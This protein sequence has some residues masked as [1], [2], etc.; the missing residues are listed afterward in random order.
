MPSGTD[1]HKSTNDNK[2]PKKPSIPAGAKDPTKSQHGLGQGMGAERGIIGTRGGVLGGIGMVV[3]AL[4]GGQK[5]IDLTNHRKPK[6]PDWKH[7]T[8]KSYKDLT[9]DA[10]AHYG[11]ILRNKDYGKGSGYSRQS[12]IERN[13]QYMIQDYNKLN[14][15][16]PNDMAN[17][18]ANYNNLLYD[19]LHQKEKLRVAS[20]YY[21]TAKEPRKPTFPLPTRK[22]FKTTQDY[23][24]W[25][26]NEAIIKFNWGQWAKHQKGN[27]GQDKGPQDQ[28]QKKV[29]KHDDE[30][31]TDKNSKEKKVSKDKSQKDK[32]AYQYDDM[33]TWAGVISQA[34]AGGNA[35]NT[36]LAILKSPLYKSLEKSEQEKVI[37]MIN[38]HFNRPNINPSA[39]NSVNDF[40][41][42]NFSR[43]AKLMNRLHELQRNKPKG[44]VR[45]R[46]AREGPS[47][48][49][50]E[51][52]EWYRQ[53]DLIRQEV[54]SYNIENNALTGL[55]DA[56][57]NVINFG[58]DLAHYKRLQQG[59]KRDS[60]KWRHDINQLLDLEE[61]DATDNIQ[62]ARDWSQFVSLRDTTLLNKILNRINDPQYQES[63]KKKQDEI[64]NYYKHL[65]LR[66]ANNVINN[67]QLLNGVFSTKS[68]LS[69]RNIQP[70]RIVMSNIKIFM[71]QY[72]RDH[73]DE[74]STIT[75]HTILVNAEDHHGDPIEVGDNTDNYITNQ[76]LQ[77]GTHA[78]AVGMGGYLGYK[79]LLPPTD[80][81]I[82]DLAKTD[83]VE[84]VENLQ[85]LKNERSDLLEE[86]GNLREESEAVSTPSEPL[87][88]ISST[89]TN[90]GDL[91]QPEME[92]IRRG[93]RYRRPAV[94]LEESAGQSGY[95]RRGRGRDII[96]V[97]KH[98]TQDRLNTI[99]EKI[100]EQQSELRTGIARTDYTLENT[101]LSI[102]RGIKT[103]AGIIAGHRAYQ[104]YMKPIINVAT[105]GPIK[106]APAP[107]QEKYEPYIIK[108]K[109]TQDNIPPP[110]TLKW[111]RYN[112]QS[113]PHRQFKTNPR[114]KLSFDEIVYITEG[115]RGIEKCKSKG[116]YMTANYQSWNE[117]SGQE[118]NSY[119][120]DKLNFK[121]AVKNIKNNNSNYITPI[122]S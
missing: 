64:Y 17:E 18:K 119:C 62:D 98:E 80:K 60:A 37:N 115:L 88:P 4:S 116:Y 15:L 13:I 36:L 11:K 120:K 25:L 99:N 79:G 52:K 65:N 95:G 3:G 122:L 97:D 93:T 105:G 19:A 10:L 85:N 20:G 30:A 56:Q 100:G 57:I 59:Y 9:H 74:F 42:N 73:Q 69:K 76:L 45:A 112:K 12:I 53:V 81:L 68:L 26:V 94:K 40:F 39:R 103:G 67:R 5:Y 63:S 109:K 101:L 108:A 107:K 41:V 111:N 72:E 46:T 54:H 2:H 75:S 34:K 114:Q 118:L 6:T 28:K 27:Q 66:R 71:N 89:E 90:P 110:P 87:A 32:G 43:Q 21:K 24:E 14:R 38:K 58:T 78:L 31:D 49:I 106:L 23:N 35:T 33:R 47:K 48:V 51:W 70:V 8:K 77:L 83:Q 121:K 102:D 50:Q 92:G 55:Q 117:H 86:M 84:Q 1:H 29:V 82:G 22:Q 44:E 96:E 113:K 7:I 61:N 16:H 91:G 104:S